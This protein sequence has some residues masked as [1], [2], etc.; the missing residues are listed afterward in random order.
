MTPISKGSEANCRGT[1]NNLA[2]PPGFANLD[3]FGQFSD[4]MAQSFG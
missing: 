4:L 2:V 3:A 1:E